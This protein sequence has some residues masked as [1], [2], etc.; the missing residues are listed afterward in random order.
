MLQTSLIPSSSITNASCQLLLVRRRYKRIFSTLL[1]LLETRLFHGMSKKSDRI[2]SIHFVHHLR[3][4]IAR[5]HYLLI[6]WPQISTNLNLQ[7]IQSCARQ[8]L[9]LRFFPSHTSHISGLNDVK[10]DRINNM[11]AP[12]NFGIQVGGTGERVRN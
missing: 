6:Q 1:S 5:C 7:L 9:E 4:P 8:Q 2:E 3:F 11:N 10:M 12:E